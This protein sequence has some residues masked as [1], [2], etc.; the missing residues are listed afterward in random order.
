MKRL[1]LLFFIPFIVI[2]FISFIVFQKACDYTMN[3]QAQKPIP[4]NHQAHLSEYDVGSC[5]TCHKYYDNGR[6]MGIPSVNDCKDCHNGEDAEEVKAFMNYN[7]TDIPWEPFSK[8]PDLVYFSHKVV[9]ASPKR[10]G[11]ASCHGDKA[12]ST[13]TEKITGKMKMGRCMDCHD[14]LKISNTCAVCHD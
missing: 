3:F 14:A 4:F 11:C 12:N 2:A 13:S 9:L 7:D 10:V 5:D 8:Q 1:A 6:F